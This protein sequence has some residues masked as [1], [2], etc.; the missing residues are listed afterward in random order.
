M[1]STHLIRRLRCLEAGL[2]VGLA[3]LLS[4]SCAPSEPE[5]PENAVV[6]GAL[7]PFSGSESAIGRNLEQAMLLAIEHLNAAGGLDGR[8][9]DL[10]SRDSHSSAERGIHQLAALLYKDRVDY[11]VGPEENDLAHEISR[12]VKELDR[13]H[14][15]PGYAAPSVARSERK[16]GWMRLAPTPFD[17]GCALAKD[18]IRDGIRTVN[19]LAAWDDYN[20]KVS[21]EF[22]TNFVGLRGRVL[23]SVPLTAGEHTYTDKIEFAFGSQPDRTL[24]AA[25]PATASTIVTEW[26]VAG[27]PGDWLLGPAL[28]AEAFLANIPAGVLDGYSGVSPSLSLRSEC[29]IVDEAEEK[30]E[31]TTGNAAAFIEHF[32][33]R[34]GGEVPFPAA[35]FYYDGVVLIAMGLVYAQATSG[36][37][38]DSGNALQKIIRELNSPD[39]EPASWRDLKTAMTRLREGVP[40]RYVGA[41]AEYEFDG[42][43]ANKH[44]FMQKWTIRD[45]AF[46]DLDPVPVTCRVRQ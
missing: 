15:L 35:H 41:A 2:L 34:W 39:N 43:G 9:F 40:L 11:L 4:A 27:R 28:R 14:M 38:P 21:S 23:P 30:V 33:R 26:T 7:L 36:K 12:D 44:H 32:S 13:F 29:Q 1:G 6:I 46:V 18:A 42:Y 45:E 10:L 16:G 5:R 24:L 25:F 31:C 8:P 3:S 22:A 20:A 19:T 37:I 17:I